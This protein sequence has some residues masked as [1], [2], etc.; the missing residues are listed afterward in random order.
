MV[1]K[2]DSERVRL[3]RR[4]VLEFLASSVDVSTSPQILEYI[5]RY[6][7]KPERFGMPEGGNAEHRDDAMPGHHNVPTGG[8]PSTVAQ[9]VKIDN[10]LYI[11][12][13]G[14]CILCYKCVQ[15]C[16]VEAQNTFAI[17][18]AGRGFD[19][20]ISTEYDVPLTDSACV[21][22]ATALAYVQPAR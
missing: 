9:P 21:S 6:D 11:R 12:D 4:L 13:Y 8:T 1:V 7:A 16:G 19:T 18:V 15:A 20:R 14:K 5:R 2:T 17:A 3:S 10:D 22:V